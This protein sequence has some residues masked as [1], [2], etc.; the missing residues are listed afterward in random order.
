MKITLSCDFIAVVRQRICCRLL[1][2][3]VKHG[4]NDKRAV[5][6]YLLFKRFNSKLN[7]N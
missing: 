1:R 2:N 3:N 6:M 4:E 5:I 7:F